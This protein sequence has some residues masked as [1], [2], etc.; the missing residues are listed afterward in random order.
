M[1]IYRMC[2]NKYVNNC[3]MNRNA[4]RDFKMLDKMTCGLYN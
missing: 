3:A 1:W 2:T 4:L